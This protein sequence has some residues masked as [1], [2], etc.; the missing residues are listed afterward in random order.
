MLL[1]IAIILFGLLYFY[2]MQKGKYRLALSLVFV[3]LLYLKFVKI[4]L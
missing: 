3:V 2:F 1:D 4:D